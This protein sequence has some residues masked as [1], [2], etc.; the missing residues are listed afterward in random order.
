ME[1]VF[2]E[3]SLQLRHFEQQYNTQQIFYRPTQEFFTNLSVA[4][5]NQS[6]NIIISYNNK[7][8]KSDGVSH[9]VVDITTF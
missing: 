6:Y 7:R 4:Q 2:K 8:L 1:K 3:K 5:D 9:C